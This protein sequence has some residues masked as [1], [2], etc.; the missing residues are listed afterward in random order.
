MQ[1]CTNSM[2]PQSEI[3]IHVQFEV[4]ILREVHPLRQKKSKQFEGKILKSK[5]C[6]VI[7]TSVFLCACMARA[8]IS[9]RQGTSRY[10]IILFK[11]QMETICSGSFL[12]FAKKGPPSAHTWAIA[13]KK[14]GCLGEDILR[15]SSMPL[16]T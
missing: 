10:L 5:L 14:G 15:L 6:A 7:D 16:I 3:I 12:V 9:L 2:T 4:Q 1:L 11:M 13:A 8:G